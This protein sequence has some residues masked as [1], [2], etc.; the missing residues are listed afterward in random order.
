MDSAPA[1]S[2]RP[3]FQTAD[4]VRIMISS[5][6]L[7]TCNRFEPTTSSQFRWA[8]CHRSF[9]DVKRDLGRIREQETQ[10][11]AVDRSLW[12]VQP[13]ANRERHLLPP[14]ARVDEAARHDD[15]ENP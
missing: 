15:T 8:T 7:G 12:F 10:R 13:S 2:L 14:G 6:W 1:P 11:A 4:A 3:P 5:L 9:L